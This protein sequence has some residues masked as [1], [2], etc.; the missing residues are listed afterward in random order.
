MDRKIIWAD[1][2]VSDLESIAEFISRDSAAYA[3]ASVQRVLAAARSLAHQPE[4]GRWVPELNDE[5]IREIFIHNY[6]L[7]YRIS[8]N[9]IEILAIIHGKRDFSSAWSEKQR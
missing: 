3:S 5:A 9:R 2:A 8:A 7:V 4:M 6:R 1:S